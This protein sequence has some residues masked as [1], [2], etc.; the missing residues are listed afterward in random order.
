[1]RRGLYTRGV[2]RFPVTRRERRYHELRNRLDLSPAAV[3]YL[4]RAARTSGTTWPT[5]RG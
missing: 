1:M 2:E 3:R 5:A 4:R